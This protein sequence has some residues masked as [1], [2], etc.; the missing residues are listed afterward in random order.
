VVGQYLK[1]KHIP[2]KIECQEPWKW[3]LIISEGR[4]AKLQNRR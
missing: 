2:I 3:G 4:Q 1:K